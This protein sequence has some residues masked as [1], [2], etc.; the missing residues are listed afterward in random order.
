MKNEVVMR[1]TEFDQTVNNNKTSGKNWYHGL[2]GNWWWGMSEKHARRH[3]VKSEEKIIKREEKARKKEE[4]AREEVVRLEEERIFAN[5][6][7]LAST[8]NVMCGIATYTKYLLDNLHRIVPN[9]FVV[10]PIIDGELKYKSRGKL[11]HLQHEFGI[12]PKPPEKIRGKLIVTWH[13]VSKHTDAAIKMYES[14][15]DVVAHIVHS[16]YM[17]RSINSSKDIWVAPHGST[18]IPEMRKE[19]ARKILGININMPIGFIFG[20]QSGDKNYQRLID[21]ARK[22][23][24]HIIISGAQ[25]RLGQSFNI[26]NDKNVTFINRFIDENEVNLYALASDILL[27][28]YVGKDH[29]SVS[30]ALHRIIGAGRPIVCSDIKHFDDVDHGEDCLKFKDQKGLEKSI[31]RA[32][33]NIEKFGL[34][35]RRYA[36]KTSWENVARRHIE[37]YK[38]YTTL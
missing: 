32:L 36:I 20:F 18:L 1:L 33:E 7:V 5:K 29:Y 31:M 28:D 15:Y 10:D 35:A 13:T 26:A 6:I 21:A 27:F 30:G 25:H 23:G 17:R 2:E 24:I 37:I 4:K 19:D 38:R 22:T 16:E 12:V 14:K 8:W 3:T 34:A 11:V 9:S